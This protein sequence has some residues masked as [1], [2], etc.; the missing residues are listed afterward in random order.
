M[1]IKINENDV[2]S[3][4]LKVPSEFLFWEKT[5]NDWLSTKNVMGHLKEIE[6]GTSSLGFFFTYPCTLWL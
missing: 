5:H 4:N 2:S 3:Y 1:D 6:K